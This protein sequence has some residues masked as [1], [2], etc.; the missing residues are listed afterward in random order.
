M[1]LERSMEQRDSQT[2]CIRVIGK[3]IKVNGNDSESNIINYCTV[4]S[5]QLC[6]YVSSVLSYVITFITFLEFN[7]YFRNVTKRC[8]LPF[9]CHFKGFPI[10]YNHT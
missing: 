4:H 1:E 8:Y 10:Q 2:R 3:L 9:Y 6:D 5:F 7:C